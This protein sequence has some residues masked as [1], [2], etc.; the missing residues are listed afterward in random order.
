MC[1]VYQ[2]AFG[3]DLAQ[4]CYRTQWKQPSATG[5]IGCGFDSRAP[6]ITESCVLVYGWANLKKLSLHRQWVRSE[7]LPSSPFSLFFQS[8]Q[9]RCHRASQAFIACDKVNISAVT[10]SKNAVGE[11]IIYLNL[12]ET[13]LYETENVQFTLP[14]AKC[15]RHV[16]TSVC[17]YNLIEFAN[18]KMDF[19]MIIW[20]PREVVLNNSLFLPWVTNHLNPNPKLPEV[21]G[22]FLAVRLWVRYVSF[23]GPYK[24]AWTRHW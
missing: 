12:T 3:N 21:K 10:A 16:K 15:Q 24:R 6:R 17:I 14:E 13:K 1:T 7:S 8:T 11:I 2:S 22:Y 19:N 20:V 23:W 9:V 18:D 5:H 4:H